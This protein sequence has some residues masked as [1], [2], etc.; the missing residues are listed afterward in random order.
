MADPP[1]AS[2]ESYLAQLKWYGTTLP[3]MR[4]GKLREAKNLGRL[5]TAPEDVPPPIPAHRS[6]RA[7][8]SRAS[9]IWMG[10]PEARPPRPAACLQSRMLGPIDRLPARVHPWHGMRHY[11]RIDVRSEL[12]AVLISMRFSGQQTKICTNPESEILIFWRGKPHQRVRFTTQNSSHGTARMTR[13]RACSG[14][15]LGATRKSRLEGK[16]RGGGG[17]PLSLTFIQRTK[18]LSNARS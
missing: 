1:R 15:M 14:G 18:M 7:E 8:E 16:A 12:T 11:G 6:A 13:I 3:S 10:V 5:N 2:N 9:S 17:D 4:H